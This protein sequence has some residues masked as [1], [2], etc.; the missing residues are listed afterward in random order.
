MLR[1]YC[2]HDRKEAENLIGYYLYETKWV[3]EDETIVKCQT[4]P[5]AE[6]SGMSWKSI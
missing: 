3:V 6:V 5:F 2:I 1:I 4:L